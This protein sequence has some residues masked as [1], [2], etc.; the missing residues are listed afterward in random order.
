M[1]YNGLI[2]DNLEKKYIKQSCLLSMH[3]FSIC[4]YL[5]SFLRKLFML[6]V[7]RSLRVQYTYV[8]HISSLC[9]C[10]YSELQGAAPWDSMTQWLASD[11]KPSLCCQVI[12]RNLFG[13][14]SIWRGIFH[15]TSTI[16]HSNRSYERR[17]MYWYSFP[18]QV[19]SVITSRLYPWFL[20]VHQLYHCSSLYLLLNSLE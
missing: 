15:L 7:T 18:A 19:R 8:S 12:V 16:L 20:I 5:M 6:C 10:W 3:H 1:L 9:H 4:N 2:K 14:L 13:L 17:P 11:G